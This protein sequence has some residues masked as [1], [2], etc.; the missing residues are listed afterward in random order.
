MKQLVVLAIMFALL[1]SSVFATDADITPAAITMAQS[2]V[3]TVEFCILD[4]LNVPMN[5]DVVLGN[6]CKDVDGLFGCSVSG[7]DIFSP[8]GFS[9]VPVDATTG[10]DGCT[11]VTLTTSLGPSDGGLFYYTINGFVG[12]AFAGGET[13]Q[14]FVPEFGVA[15]AGAALV[16]AGIYIARKRKQ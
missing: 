9:V 1:V 3:R 4:N 8:A 6:V 10:V 11:D 14:V 16:G 15:A 2:D 12:D 7:G 5:V 13:A